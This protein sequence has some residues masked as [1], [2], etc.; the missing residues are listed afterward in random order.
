MTVGGLHSHL[1]TMCVSLTRRLID[2]AQS[3]CLVSA[4]PLFKFE[5]SDEYTELFSKLPCTWWTGLQVF[6]GSSAFIFLVPV[7]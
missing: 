7:C 4:V 6:W 5:D 2:S 1:L 3:K